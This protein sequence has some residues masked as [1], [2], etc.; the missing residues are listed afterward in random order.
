MI[1]QCTK[2]LENLTQR[3]NIATTSLITTWRKMSLTMTD[4][5]KRF[6]RRI[7]AQKLESSLIKSLLEKKINLVLF[8]SGRRPTWSC[9]HR[10]VA[11]RYRSM[12]SGQACRSCSA[13]HIVNSVR[14]TKMLMR[15][16]GSRAKQAKKISPGP[17]WGARKSYKLIVWLWR[18]V[19]TVSCC[20]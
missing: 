9:H 12:H 3:C 11:S 19:R 8:G 10:S 7:C 5:N 6:L 1:H 17:S 4:N 16:P 14:I 18:T 20:L 13:V 2:T 15:G